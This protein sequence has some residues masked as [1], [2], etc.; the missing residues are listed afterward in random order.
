MAQAIVDPAELRRF[1]SQ[2]KQFNN[3]LRDELSGL[4]GQLSALGDSW[5]D[6]EHEKFLREFE[7]TM[8]VLNHFIEVAEEQL[9]LLVRKAEK[10]EEY[11]R[12]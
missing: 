11:L 6:Q 5:R 12:R 8:H 3:N 4:G 2:L 10:I 7:E 1:A 9:P